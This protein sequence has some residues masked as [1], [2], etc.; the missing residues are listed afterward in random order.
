MKLALLFL[1][2]FAQHESFE[3]IARRFENDRD[4]PVDE[5]I[6]AME[7]PA[8]IRLFEYSFTSPV[9]GRA[10]GKHVLAA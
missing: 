2:A 10:D 8:G 1:F 5:K 6:T 7:G 4:Q 3:E 9:G